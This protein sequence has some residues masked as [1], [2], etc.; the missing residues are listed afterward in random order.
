MKK[1]VL[2]LVGVTSTLEAKEMP[3]LAAAYRAS[4]LVTVA[5]K[6]SSS[7]RAHF[8]K[9]HPCPSTGKKMGHCPG[10]VVDHIRALK[11]GGADA[12]RNMQWQT[13]S[14]AKRKDRWE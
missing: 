13:K 3:S 8:M 6:R 12:P 14:A 7:S 11:R 10:Y 2:I 4:D 5:I 9:E 1:F